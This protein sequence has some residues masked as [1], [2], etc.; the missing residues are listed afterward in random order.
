MEFSDFGDFKERITS[1]YCTNYYIQEELAKVFAII[2][3]CASH[4][5]FQ[6]L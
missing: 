4:E 6:E 2:N 1:S 5:R 3:S